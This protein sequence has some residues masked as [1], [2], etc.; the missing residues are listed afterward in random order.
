MPSKASAKKHDHVRVVDV[1]SLEIFS[2]A[3]LRI[4]SQY[5]TRP[6]TAV[7]LVLEETLCIVSK[8]MRTYI[9]YRMGEPLDDSLDSPFA[10]ADQ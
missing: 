5:V 7:V 2:C 9:P 3:L 8:H 4:H 6:H 1:S 10:R